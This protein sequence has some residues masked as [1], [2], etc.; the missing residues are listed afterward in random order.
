MTTGSGVVLTQD[1]IVNGT[2]GIKGDTNHDIVDKFLKVYKELDGIEIPLDMMDQIEDKLELDDQQFDSWLQAKLPEIT[3]ATE[4]DETLN[5]EMFD[6]F[7]PMG[8]EQKPAAPDN[9]GETLADFLSSM[10]E[11]GNTESGED[12]EFREE[13]EK[14]SP[15]EIKNEFPNLG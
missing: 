15:D 1:E 10:K 7:K 12:Q 11:T 6:N 9:K 3:G 8:G 2:T 5:N 14:E 13:I 4:V